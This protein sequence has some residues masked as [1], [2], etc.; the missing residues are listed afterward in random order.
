MPFGGAAIGALLA[1]GRGRKPFTTGPKTRR[2]KRKPRKLTTSEAAIKHY[3]ST[4]KSPTTRK[5]KRRTGGVIGAGARVAARAVLGRRGAGPRRKTGGR[6]TIAGT[7]GFGRGTRRRTTTSSATSRG[8]KRGPSTRGA[9]PG[10]IGRSSRG[11][12]ARRRSSAAGSATKARAS[13]ARRPSRAR[14][15]HNRRGRR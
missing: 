3:E 12:A 2:P 7:I 9:A 4:R 10:I 5:P 15:S 13:R 6:P 1:G 14:N 11:T 8:G